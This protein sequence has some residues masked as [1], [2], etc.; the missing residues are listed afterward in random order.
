MNKWNIT[1]PDIFGLKRIMYWQAFRLL[2]M[3]LILFSGVRLG[4]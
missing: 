4:N 3:T 2:I 1:M